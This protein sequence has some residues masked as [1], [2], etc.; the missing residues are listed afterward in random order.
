[1]VGLRGVTR[2]RRR[3]RQLQTEY[4]NN[5]YDSYKLNATMIRLIA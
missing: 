5:M 1:M 4:D 2:D 3:Q